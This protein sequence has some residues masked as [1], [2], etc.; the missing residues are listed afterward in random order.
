MDIV[1]VSNYYN[2]HQKEV[3]ETL[4]SLSHN[5][6]YFIETE[7]ISEERRQLGWGEDNKPSYVLEYQSDKKRCDDLILASDVLICGGTSDEFFSERLKTGK[8]VFRYEE[9]FFKDG[10]KAT[11]RPSFWKMIIKCHGAYQGKPVYMLCANGYLPRELAA[12]HLYKEKKLRWG[13]FPEFIKYDSYAL[14][15]SKEC[16]MKKNKRIEIVWCGRFIWWKHPE[17]VVD[18]AKYLK[19][20]GIHIHIN[21]I[22]DG[23]LLQAIQRQIEA[24]KLQSEVTL[25]GA[26][27]H[28]LVRKE[29]EK[30]SIFLGTSG[31][32][33]GWGAVLNEAMNSCCVAVVNA[34]MGAA[35]F[36]IEHGKNGFVYHKREQLLKTM[37]EIC[38]Q[39]EENAQS[40]LLRSIANHAYSTIQTTWNGTEAATRLYHFIQ[41]TK[42]G[43]CLEKGK[44]PGSLI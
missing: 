37:K 17:L 8:L 3:A 10:L 42:E 28:D 23:P 34:K 32:E 39:L 4:N 33:E 44:G 1:F 38:I 18:V 5:C 21:M 19:N 20:N 11:L 22:G 26:I 27:Q 36:L 13:Y 35:P 14:L 7:P 2:H 43:K 30:A 16:Q 6:F 25:T 15:D 40:E 41:C 12:L 29:M 9:R 24:E 31:R